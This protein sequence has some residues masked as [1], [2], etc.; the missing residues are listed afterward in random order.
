MCGCAKLQ[1][2]SICRTYPSCFLSPRSCSED[3]PLSF[4]KFFRYGFA[5]RWRYGNSAAQPTKRLASARVILRACTYITVTSFSHVRVS[6]AAQHV[7]LM[8]RCAW[9]KS[10]AGKCKVRLVQRER[11]SNTF[12]QSSA[13]QIGSQHRCQLTE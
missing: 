7:L 12:V 1:L 10:H 4:T 6:A 8:L 3:K 11:A 13:E 2:S 5:V 9:G